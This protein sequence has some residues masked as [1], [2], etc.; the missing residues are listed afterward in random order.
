MKRIKSAPANLAEMIN[1]KKIN[2]SQSNKIVIPI[3]I[4]NKKYNIII[5]EIDNKNSEQNFIKND[6][7]KIINTKIINT[8]IIEYNKFKSQKNTLKKI[9]TFLSDVIGDTNI[10][11]FEQN[12]LITSLINYF[13]ENVLNKDKLKEI[14]VFILQT[15]A[16]YV[17]MLLLHS[18]FINIFQEQPLLIENNN[19]LDL[20]IK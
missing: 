15:L 19:I 2:Y 5:E 6:N 4:I 10:L 20:C 3:P 17:I 8:N 13:S 16:R 7:S 18:H 12:T 9:G 14:Y 1:R 11:P